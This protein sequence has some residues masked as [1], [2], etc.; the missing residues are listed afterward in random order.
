MSSCDARLGRSVRTA[1]GVVALLVGLAAAPT[2]GQAQTQS[3]LGRVTLI[4][5]AAPAVHLGAAGLSSQSLDGAAPSDDMSIAV[6][7]GYR[8]ELRRAGSPAVTLLRDDR[9]GLVS[10]TQIRAQLPAS[11]A[12]PLLLDL[13]V[14]PAL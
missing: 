2:Q 10:W 12:G 13:I 9:P 4:A 5:H 11:Q 3:G 1:L 14:T 8:V 7:T 6:N